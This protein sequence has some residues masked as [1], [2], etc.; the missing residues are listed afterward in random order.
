[1]MQL[2][3]EVIPW[4]FTLSRLKKAGD[5]FCFL[6]QAGIPNVF[7]Y[8]APTLAEM[9]L[10]LVEPSLSSSGRKGSVAWLA[11]AINIEEAQ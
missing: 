3:K 4:I 8:L 6:S 10:Q 9:R 1:M 7:F 11:E 5:P 2:P